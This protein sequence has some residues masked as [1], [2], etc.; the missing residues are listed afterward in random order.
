MAVEISHFADVIYGKTSC[1][2]ADSAKSVELVY[3]FVRS[4]E[5]KGKVLCR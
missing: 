4:A 1:D 2:P 5:N 3:L